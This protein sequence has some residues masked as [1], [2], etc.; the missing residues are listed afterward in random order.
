MVFPNTHT[1]FIYNTKND[2]DP[3]C[4]NLSFLKKKLLKFNCNYF[5]IFNDFNKAELLFLNKNF[6]L[7]NNFFFRDLKLNSYKYFYGD[8][9][10]INKLELLLFKWKRK[11]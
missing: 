11:S 3:W 2:V 1:P 5:L 10:K 8:K 6:K 4:N 9:I 7:V